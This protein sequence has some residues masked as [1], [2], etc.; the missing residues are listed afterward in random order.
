MSSPLRCVVLSIAPMVADDSE[1]GA[2]MTARQTA[3]LDLT[4]VYTL[5]SGAPVVARSSTVVQVGRESSRSLV[6]H[7]AP[8]D[9]VQI[10]TSL[11]GTVCAGDVLRRYQ[12]DQQLWSELLGRLLDAELLVPAADWTFPGVGAGPFLEPERDSL[13]HRHGVAVARR[14]MQGRQDAI[15]VVRGS[16]RVATSVATSL[17]LAGIG[18]VHQQPD[19][20]LRL[21]DLP[22]FPAPTHSWADRSR[23]P[24]PSHPGD[25]PGIPESATRDLAAGPSPRTGVPTRA[26]SA[27]LAANLR[28]VA[29][30]VKVHPPAAHHRVGLVVLAGD[31]PPAPSLAAEL[32]RSCTAHLAVCAG[33]SAA[34]VGPLVLPGRSSCLI[35]ALHS[36]ADL[37]G[38]RPAFEAGLRREFVVPP[39]QLVCSIT[40]LA[41]ADVLD[42]LDGIN[43]PT[44]V[45]GTLE[46]Q[47]GEKGPRRRSWAVHPKCGCSALWPPETED[48]SAPG[49][50]PR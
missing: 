21:T 4:G 32:T 37:D 49:P 19:R 20:A 43:V 30:S 42:H 35:C 8:T 6:L 39:V 18:H 46:W 2:A 1:S 31:G 34:V 12:A 45:D 9:S 17:A 23:T 36:R 41:V 29:P 27:R 25:G 40:A 16:G 24:P 50:L 28:R 47:L 38:T 11:D 22:D 7:H 13:V 5:I 48:S 14:V 44:T 3:P 15:I 10:L 26:D 33:L